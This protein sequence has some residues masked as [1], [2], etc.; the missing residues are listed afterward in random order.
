MREVIKQALGQAESKADRDLD[1]LASQA[2]PSV[3][4]RSF[5]LAGAAAGGGVMQSLPSQMALPKRPTPKASP[6]ACVRI[7]GDGQIVL[8]TPYIE[9]G[10]GT[11][12]WIPM[13]IAEGR[14]DLANYWRS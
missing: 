4:R 11:Y 14:R 5:L 1:Q 13:Q 10:Q 9:M 3:S 7:E 6:N 8:T 2:G 12:T